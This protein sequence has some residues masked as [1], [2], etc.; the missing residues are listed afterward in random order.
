[1]VAFYTWFLNK[2]EHE[3][4]LK[5]AYIKSL[6]YMMLIILSVCNFFW[7]NTFSIVK[8]ILGDTIIRYISLVLSVGLRFFTVLSAI[9]LILFV[10]SALLDNIP[11]KFMKSE[12]YFY[13]GILI[14]GSFSRLKDSIENI[15]IFLIAAYIFSYDV[16]IQ[17]KSIYSE[18]LWP[19]FLLVMSAVFIMFSVPGIINR[20]FTLR[21]WTNYLNKKEKLTPPKNGDTNL[22]NELPPSKN[23]DTNLNGELLSLKM[24]N[25]NLEKEILFLEAENNRLREKDVSLKEQGGTEKYI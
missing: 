19:I 6:F 15:T 25:K 11:Y 4:Q 12:T 13:L 5:I 20:F 3:L 18:S 1:M 22:N 24:M 16:F 9:A 8:V 10:I 14:H 21:S 2:D 17:Y 23:G 7:S